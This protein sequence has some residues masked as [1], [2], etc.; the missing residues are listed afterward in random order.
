MVP[1][2]AQNPS[3]IPIKVSRAAQMIQ[4]S[5]VWIKLPHR[6]VNASAHILAKNCFHAL[7]VKRHLHKS[8]I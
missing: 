4:T 8:L 3:G 2:E 6:T 5:I 7:N 1:S